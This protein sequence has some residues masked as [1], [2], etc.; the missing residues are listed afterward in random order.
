MYELTL[1]KTLVDLSAS[2][3]LLI[4]NAKLCILLQQVIILDQAEL[5]CFVFS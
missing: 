1:M 4:I 5:I 2:V 3:A